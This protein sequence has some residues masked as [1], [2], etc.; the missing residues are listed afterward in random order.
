MW[1]IAYLLSQLIVQEESSET[2]QFSAEMFII[3]EKLV[4][5]NKSNSWQTPS[6][7]ELIKQSWFLLISNTSWLN[8]KRRTC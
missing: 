4:C 5:M 3:T 6:Q 8:L 1:T 7:K 2:L